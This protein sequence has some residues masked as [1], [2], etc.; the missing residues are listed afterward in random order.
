MPLQKP[1]YI[2]PRTGRDYELSDVR[3]RSDDGHPMMVTEQA[4]IDRQDID[5]RLRSLWRY[6]AA[7]PGVDIAVSMLNAIPGLR[8]VTPEG[9]FYIFCS[10]EGAIGKSTSQGKPIETDGDFVFALLDQEG[11]AAVQGEAFG[12]SPF[13]RISYALSIDTMREAITGIGRFCASLS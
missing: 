10:C 13:F 7:L 9:A 4:G 8:C 1:C 11:V 6:Q 5:T 2:D 12:M 3:W